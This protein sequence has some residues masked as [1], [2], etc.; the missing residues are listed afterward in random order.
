MFASKEEYHRRYDICKSCGHFDYILKRCTACGC[1]MP[2]KAKVSWMKCP[3]GFWDVVETACPIDI[4]EN[5]EGP[6]DL[7]DLENVE[8]IKQHFKNLKT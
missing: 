1:F 6:E 8:R 3:H 7:Q 4:N 2:F 5:I